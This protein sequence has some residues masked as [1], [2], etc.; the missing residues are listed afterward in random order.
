MPY[1]LVF[2]R[3]APFATFGFGFE[4]DHR[5]KAST[6]MSDTAR[7]SGTVMFDRSSIGKVTGISSGT[8]YQGLGSQ[9]AALM[10]K[11]HSTVKTSISNQRTSTNHVSFTAATEGA[12]PMLPKSPDIDTYVDF[13]ARWSAGALN[14]EGTVRGNSFPN[15]E[16]FVLDGFGKAALLF[17]GQTSGG[18]QTGPLTGLAGSGANK[19]IGSFSK[20]VPVGPSD[21]FVTSSVTCPVTKMA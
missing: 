10:G 7:T 5:T 16:V 11:H 6:S 20:S 2:R 15:A 1:Y 21:G 4:G 12:N 3:Y 17:D 14:F 8:T 19:R 9:V 18:R 13:S